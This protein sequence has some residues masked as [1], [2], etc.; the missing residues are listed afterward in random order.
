[1]CFE[2][3][4][5][6]MESYFIILIGFEI[7]MGIPRETIRKPSTGKERKRAREMTK[8]TNRIRHVAVEFGY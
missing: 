1:M 4:F 3:L 7:I 2:R 5:Y 8:S 6:E